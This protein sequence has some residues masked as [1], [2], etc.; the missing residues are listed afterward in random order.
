M[1]TRPE[2]DILSGRFYADDVHSAFTWMRENEPVYHDRA[3]GLHAVDEARGHHEDL[4]GAGSLLQRKKGFVRT[5][6]RPP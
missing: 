6:D 1:S 4:Q 5:R 2:Y 3:N